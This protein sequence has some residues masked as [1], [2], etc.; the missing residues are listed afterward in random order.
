MV[1]GQ[2]RARARCS[3]CTI[4]LNLEEQLRQHS[5]LGRSRATRSTRCEGRRGVEGV[6]QVEVDGGVSVARVPVLHKPRRR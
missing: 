4:L 6:G 3:P 5:T 1:V 2:G